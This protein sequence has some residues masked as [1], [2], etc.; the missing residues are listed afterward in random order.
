TRHG[1]FPP[2]RRYSAA[3]PGTPTAPPPT[4]P[5]IDV[6]E[7]ASALDGAATPVAKKVREIFKPGPVRDALAGTWIGHA[8]HPL[9][10]DVVIGSWTSATVL[11]LIGGPDGE[12]AA[13]RLIALGIA[14]YVPTALT[15]GSDWADSEATDDEVRRIGLT[16]ALINVSALALYGASLSARRNG[17]TGRGKLL[18]LAGAGVM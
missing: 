18:A 1:P 13:E 11:D 7:Q 16:H 5:L 9:L 2:C 17:Q 15:G 8:L 12:G 4:S 6:V 10:T 14:A 3:M